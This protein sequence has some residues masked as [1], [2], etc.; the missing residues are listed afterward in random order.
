MCVLCGMDRVSSS[1]SIILNWSANALRT[2]IVM[3]AN[4]LKSFTGFAVVVV[5]AIVLMFNKPNGYIL[6][7]VK[8]FLIISMNCINACFLAY[9]YIYITI[10]VTE[11]E[12]K[13]ELWMWWWRRRLLVVLLSLLWSI[14]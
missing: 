3:D 7:K 13:I 5:I 4:F 11:R 10:A 9:S 8:D 6:K 12:M 1:M 14:I 2:T